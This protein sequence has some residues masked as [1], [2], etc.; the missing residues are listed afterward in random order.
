MR[1]LDAQLEALDS[2]RCVRLNDEEGLIR[3]VDD[4]HNPKNENL[5]D[6]LQ[7]DAFSDDTSGK[8]ACYVVMDTDNDI[9]CFFALKTGI[10]YSEFEELKLYEQHK[11]LKIRFL[12]LTEN[13]RTKETEEIIERLQVELEESKKQI[14]RKLGSFDELPKH[15]HV[16]L[17]YPAMEI[18]HFCVNEGYREKWEKMNFGDRNRIGLTLFWHFIVQKISEVNRLVGCEYAYLFAADGT[19][20][21]LLVNHYKNLMGFRDDLDVLTIQPMYDFRC[22]FLCNTVEAIVEGRE[23]FY[24]HFNDNEDIV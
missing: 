6:Y 18:S 3:W 11:K 14:L 8:V 24:A 7:G 21:R 19:P 22:T 2:L 4:F 9:L 17:A 10:L 13:R 1:I 23:S 15:K 20:D 16:A 12:E 5:V